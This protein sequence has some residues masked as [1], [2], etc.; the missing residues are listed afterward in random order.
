MVKRIATAIMLASTVAA[1]MMTVPAYAARAARS[2]DFN[3]DGRG[4]L[5]IGAPGEDI[6][7]ADAGAVHVLYGRK[8]G[9]GARGD[10]FFH[11]DVLAD[12]PENGDGFG[13]ATAS[14]DFDAD[15]YADLAIG[16]P[17]ESSELEGSFGAVHVL[18]GSA[19]GLKRAG[20][21]FW[22]Q[23]LIGVD[24]EASDR[25]GAALTV[26]R[27]NNDGYLD[28]AIGHPGETV[29][30]IAGA[31]AVTVLYGS[32]DGLTATGVQLWHQDVTGVRDEAEAY[33]DPGT[34]PQP[35]NFGAALASGDLDGDGDDDLVVGVPGEIVG[36]VHEAGAVNVLFARA[37]GLAATGN[38]IISQ[39]TDG[40]RDEAESYRDG[41][42]TYGDRFGSS[43]AIGDINADGYADVAI[44][45]PDERIQLDSHYTNDLG[46]GAVAV[47]YGGRSGPTGRDDL[48]HLNAK[49]VRGDAVTN[50]E[51]RFG[52]ALAIGRL[53]GDRFA[54]LAVGSPVRDGGQVN[55]LYGTA[56]GLTEA[57]DQLWHQDV[58]GVPGARQSGDL[59]G[60]SL[61]IRNL[62]RGA[63]ADLVIGAPGEDSGTS[64][65]AGR[66]YVMYCA[67]SGV[68]ARRVQKWEQDSRG[69]IDDG[70]HADR[71]GSALG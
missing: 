26:G 16:V 62:G 70:E 39:E 61:L 11:Q 43:L 2:G 25:F 10:Q 58:E 68:T 27:F 45:V 38:R 63:P 13:S 21:Q 33:T 34:G 59:F 32:R 24:S 64:N 55:V 14:G 44:G 41:Q 49:G 66:I 1:S 4:D 28:L 67:D 29:G 60:A 6:G 54:D 22:T 46:D 30:L 15:G 50:D 35:E 19:D 5:A 7:S 52:A 57:G 3:G 47:I 31:G 71:F 12:A 51:E 40:I 42:G 17:G 69:V 53:D 20:A 48:W 37:G 18:Y 23:D 36:D 65:D 9:L 8:D 56:R